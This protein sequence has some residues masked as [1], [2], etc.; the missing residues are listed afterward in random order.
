[1]DNPKLSLHLKAFNDKVKVMNQT[2]A[3]EIS[4]TAIEARNLH[5]ELFSLLAVI[6]ELSKS[7]QQLEAD[8]Q[9]IN[10][11]FNGGKF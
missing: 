2:N 6:A 9:T 3:R 8:N 1:M 4:L 10:L 11:E 7:N 5:S